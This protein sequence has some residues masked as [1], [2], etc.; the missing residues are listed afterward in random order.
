MPED[1][2][3]PAE[4]AVYAAYDAAIQAAF[5]ELLACYR[6]VQ[7]KKADETQ[8]EFERRYEQEA[9]KCRD[10]FAQAISS[11]ASALHDALTIIEKSENKVPK[12]KHKE[13]WF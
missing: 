10:A 3:G 1:S 9:A 2:S 7:P 5:K 8:N 12:P 6:A 11:A 13:E 4:K